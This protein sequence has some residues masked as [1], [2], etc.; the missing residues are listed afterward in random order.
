MALGGG[1]QVSAQAVSL[2][3]EHQ[4]PSTFHCLVGQPLAS[5][6]TLGAIGNRRNG[7]TLAFKHPSSP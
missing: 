6:A 2:R 1:G 7:G 4:H 5:R 3:H